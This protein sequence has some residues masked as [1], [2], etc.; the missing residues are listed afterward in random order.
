MITSSENAGVDAEPCADT[1]E[2]IS[3]LNDVGKFAADKL[4]R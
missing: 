1:G 4:L 2:G 3:F